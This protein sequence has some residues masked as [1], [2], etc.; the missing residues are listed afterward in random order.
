MPV[1]SNLELIEAL[2]EGDLDRVLGTAEGELLDF[3]EQPYRLSEPKERWELAKDVA[4]FAQHRGGLIVLGFSTTATTTLKQDIASRVR[5]IPKTM[6]IPEQYRGLIQSRIYP[7]PRDIGMSWFPPGGGDRGIFVIDVPAQDEGLKPFL[8]R[9]MPDPESGEDVVN[10]FGFPRRDGDRVIWTPPE[11]V[12]GRIQRGNLAV[13]AQILG[14]TPSNADVA[15]DLESEATATKALLSADDEPDYLLQSY[16][17]SYTQNLDMSSMDRARVALSDP[18]SLRPSGF[19]LRG[20]G[21]AEWSSD[22]I[23]ASGSGIAAR[24]NS[25]GMFTVVFLA[26]RDTL[27]WA[28]NQRVAP[29]ASLRINPLTLTEYTE[30]YFRFAEGHLTQLTVDSLW[31]GVVQARHM[32]SAD[33]VFEARP[34]TGATPITP[35]FPNAPRASTD[36]WKSAFDLSGDP[37]SDA[38][39]A[40][41][42][43]YQLFGLNESAVLYAESGRI[44]TEEILRA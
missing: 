40:L 15:V 11:Y 31:T 37:E 5:Q 32:K 44:S 1:A 12:H 39:Q 22:A 2:T 27:G 34:L 4:A 33:V 36:E 8:V 20:L 19:N 16:P 17:T 24:I 43:I 7:P 42:R 23:V 38:F 21:T 41:V 26:D 30:E 9:S 35:P 10:S 3:K 13:A 6:I 29:D 18:P 28:L 25:K 14:S